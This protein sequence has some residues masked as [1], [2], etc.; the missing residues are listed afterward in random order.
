MYNLQSL[1]RSNRINTNHKP[2]TMILTILERR[3]CF[4][5]HI[6]IALHLFVVCL[7]LLNLLRLRCEFFL[8]F[9]L[10]VFVHFFAKLQMVRE[11]RVVEH[12]LT[13]PYHLGQHGYFVV[14]IENRLAVLQIKNFNFNLRNMQMVK[15]KT[16]SYVGDVIRLYPSLVV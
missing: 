5:Q 13:E 16:K 15:R 8:N 7:E 10:L 6:D 11:Y 14:L 1:N 3:Q 2:L 9:Q 12:I 4:L